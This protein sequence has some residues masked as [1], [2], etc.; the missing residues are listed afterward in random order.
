MSYY[1]IETNI[2]LDVLEAKV[3]Q[4]FTS[5]EEAI[6]ECCKLRSNEKSF[7]VHIVT[8]T[9]SFLKTTGCRYIPENDIIFDTAN[10]AATITI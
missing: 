5:K 1:L 4:V 8:A 10:R 7:E 2:F 9:D 6:K 3:L